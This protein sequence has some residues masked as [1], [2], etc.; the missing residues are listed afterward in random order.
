MLVVEIKDRDGEERNGES[1]G[2][3]VGLHEIVVQHSHRID[4]MLTERPD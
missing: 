4:V 1:E 2:V 3:R